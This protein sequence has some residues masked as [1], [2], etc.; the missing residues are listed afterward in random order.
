MRFWLEPGD[1]PLTKGGLVWGYRGRAIGGRGEC[2]SKG[3]VVGAG[4]TGI[5]PGNYVEVVEKSGGKR[6]IESADPRQRFT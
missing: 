1:L 5:F 2:M 6:R 3:T 4:N